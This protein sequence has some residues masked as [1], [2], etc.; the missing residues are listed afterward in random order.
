MDANNLWDKIRAEYK[1]KLNAPVYES[2][3]SLSKSRIV[4]IDIFEKQLILMIENGFVRSMIENR[5]LE[6]LNSLVRKYYGEP[7]EVRIIE[8]VEDMVQRSEK[9]KKQEKI[10]NF[11]LLPRYT[12]DSF[13]VGNS[14]GFAHA[15]CL[16]VAEK[17][18]KVYNP[19]FIYG[20]VGLG[21]TH[22][23]HAIGNAILEKQTDSKILY[24]SSETFVNELITAIGN[25]KGH[26]NFRNGFRDKYRNVDVLLIDDIQFIAGKEGTQE[27]FFHTFNA[28]HQ[29]NKQIILTSDRPP[30]EIPTLEDRLRSRFEM[31]LIVDIQKPDYETRIAILRKKTR[32]EQREVPDEVTVYIARNIKSNIRE[33]EGAL[34]RIFAYSDLINKPITYQLATEALKDILDD[35]GSTEISVERIQTVV[36]KAYRIKMEDFTSKS[37]KQQ[38]AYPR[39]IAMYLCR[40]LM[41]LSLPKIGQ[42][43]GGRDHT[44]VLYACDKIEEDLKRDSELKDKIDT[45][46][47]D[48]KNEL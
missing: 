2:F 25:D 18:A 8:S 19:L 15:A 28:L 33:L 31:G 21:K 36:A 7:I 48:L 44:T 29:N 17:P 38:V 42:D 3:F 34:T 5:Y 46:I 26:G 13:V 27:E 14:N 12:F 16:A 45:M 37:R 22:L 39:Q 41:D 32:M 47:F 6:D 35:E 11:S 20:G 30:K 43:F 9:E 40:T 4:P 23:M 10:R 24:L 1:Q